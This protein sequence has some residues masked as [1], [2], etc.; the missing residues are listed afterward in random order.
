[1][2]LLNAR[3]A[4]RTHSLASGVGLRARVLSARSR[5]LAVDLCVS[6]ELSGESFSSAPHRQDQECIVSERSWPG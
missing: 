4:S 2:R 6:R 1:M 3:E 5:V